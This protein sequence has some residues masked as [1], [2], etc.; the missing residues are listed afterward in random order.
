M[1]HLV[2]TIY[3][4]MGLHT[5]PRHQD[6]QRFNVKC[7]HHMEIGNS[8]PFHTIWNQRQDLTI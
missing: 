7:G 1:I 2:L 6:L 8:V 4:P 5:Y 3:L